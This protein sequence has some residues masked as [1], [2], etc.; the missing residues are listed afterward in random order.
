M[1]KRDKSGKVLAWLFS[2]ALIL[3]ACTKTVY[4]PVDRVVTTTTTVIDTIKEI[5]TPP[6]K[7][8][9][10]TTDTISTLFTLYA[11]STAEVSNGILRH[12]LTQHARKDSVRERTVY[13]HTVD[14]VTNTIV[15]EVEVVKEVIPT[16]C[17][18]VLL[19]CFV[20]VLWKIKK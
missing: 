3:V 4:V 14:S 11:T 16:W 2:I 10:V 18:A 20:F 13:V 19:L 5:I 6:E 7:V 8:V 12:E 1:V 15:E 9:N 17:W